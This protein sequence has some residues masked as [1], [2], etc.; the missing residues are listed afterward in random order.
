MY[1]DIVI[2]S[3]GNASGFTVPKSSLVISTERKYVLVVRSGRIQKVDVTS[4][5]KS[6]HF[7]EV[8]GFLNKTDSVI[9]NAGDEIKEGHY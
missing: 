9:V 4:G 2:Y 7:V 3:Q 1:A 8:F 5:N 6:G